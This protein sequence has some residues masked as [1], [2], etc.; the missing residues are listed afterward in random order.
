MGLTSPNPLLRK[1]GAFI[2]CYRL[3]RSK[4]WIAFPA[5]MLSC[6]EVVALLLS[7]PYEV[8]KR[9]LPF[10]YDETEQAFAPSLRRR[11]LGEVSHASHIASRYTR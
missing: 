7:S 10:A 5:S 11:G 6:K 1:E 3:L 9:H 2:A 4:A 8:E